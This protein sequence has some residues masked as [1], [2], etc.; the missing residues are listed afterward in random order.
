M[1]LLDVQLQRRHYVRLGR[2]GVEIEFL[3][4]ERL[5]HISCDERL[6][7]LSR[8]RTAQLARTVGHCRLYQR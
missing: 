2:F 7:R 6:A 1:M 4:N 3:W 8:A 5:A